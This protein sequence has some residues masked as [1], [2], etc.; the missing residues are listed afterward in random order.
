MT[1]LVE[2][3]EV[4]NTNVLIPVVR[5]VTSTAKARMVGVSTHK[6][7]GTQEEAVGSEPKTG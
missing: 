7:T 4:S 2:M 1:K 6:Q 5:A 3:M